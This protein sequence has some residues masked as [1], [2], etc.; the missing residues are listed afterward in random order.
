MKTTVS[1]GT[2]GRAGQLGAVGRP[3][4]REVGEGK[5]GGWGLLGS[6]VLWGEKQ[7]Q[8]RG[9]VDLLANYE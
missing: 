4:Q 2:G 7:G 1:A 5:R 8:G 6:L 9:D 3:K